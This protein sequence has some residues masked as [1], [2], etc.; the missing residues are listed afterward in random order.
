MVDMAHHRHHWRTGTQIAFGVGGAGQAFQHVAFRHPLDGMAIFSRH[1]LGGVGV[2]NIVGRRHHAVLH[3]NLD[4][5]DDAARHAVGQFVDRDGFRNRHFAGTGGAGNLLLM[6][7]VD[8]LKMTLVGGDRAHA[9]IIVG[10]RA[11]NGKLAAAALAFGH[12]L[13]RGCLGRN[14][15]AADFLGRTFF[16]LVLVDPAAGNFHRRDRLGGIDTA[17]RFRLGML[18]GLLFGRLARVFLGLAALSGGALGLELLFLGAAAAGIVFGH[19]AGFRVGHPRIRQGRGAA[20][21]FL[22]RQLAQHNAA[23]CGALAAGWSCAAAGAGFSATGAAFPPASSGTAP[24][25]SASFRRQRPW[26]GHG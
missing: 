13:G 11:G 2:D 1:Q 21:L 26:C 23:R 16:F 6:T 25:E 14:D 5:V 22:F 24:P 7:L 10:K 9:F 12:F 17:Q 18:A 4:D 20:G 8:A 15:L 19:A 3:Q